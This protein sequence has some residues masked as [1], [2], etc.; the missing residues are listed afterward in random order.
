[1]RK[2]ISVT[3]VHEKIWA[4]GISI[5][6]CYYAED[7]S[8]FVWLPYQ[9]KQ[10]LQRAI[11]MLEHSMF[12]N[13][14]FQYDDYLDILQCS[15][16]FGQY[17]KGLLAEYAENIHVPDLYLFI[18]FQLSQSPTNYVNIWQIV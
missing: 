13:L 14:Y 6:Y 3:P 2:I 16:L 15:G 17:K 1:M 7:S 12:R 10:C 5:L 9:T 18:H 4:L 8:K 11:F